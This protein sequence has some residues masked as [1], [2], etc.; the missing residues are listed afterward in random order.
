MKLMYLVRKRGIHSLELAQLDL[1]YCQPAMLCM[2]AFLLVSVIKET[3]S[4]TIVSFTREN[5]KILEKFMDIHIIINKKIN[6][7]CFTQVDL[8]HVHVV[9]LIALTCGTVF[10]FTLLKIRTH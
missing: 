1:I 3:V 8:W 5:N 2:I 6:K 10:P 9:Q 4:V 7:K